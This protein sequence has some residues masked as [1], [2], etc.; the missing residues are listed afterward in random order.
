MEIVEWAVLIG[1]SLITLF[2]GIGLRSYATRSGQVS[3]RSANV[4]VL[5]TVS[6]VLVLC[7]ELSNLHLL[8][9]FPISILLGLLALSSPYLLIPILGKFLA[10]LW[11]IGLNRENIHQNNKIF[12]RI[13]EY[14]EHGMSIKE[15]RKRIKEE[16]PQ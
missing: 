11:S 13:S 15:A 2:W 4:M 9:M 7:T 1:A 10:R 14:H 5:F 3:Q 16:F 8:W 6:I 12:D